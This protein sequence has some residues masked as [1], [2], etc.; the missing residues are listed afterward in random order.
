MR[1]LDLPPTCLQ[2]VE[3]ELF[4]DRLYVAVDRMLRLSC[5]LA[6]VMWL[7]IVC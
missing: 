1:R 4:A 5:L 3:V 7:W 6:G 2:Y